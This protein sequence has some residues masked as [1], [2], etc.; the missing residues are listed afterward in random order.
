VTTVSESLRAPAEIPQKWY[1]RLIARAVA[2][3][4][5]PARLCFHRNPSLPFN[6]RQHCYACGASRAYVLNFEYE[7]GTAGVFIGPWKR[8]SLP[9]AQDARRVAARHLVDN[10]VAG[11][12]D[13]RRAILNPGSESPLFQRRS[14]A[15][16]SEAV[17][18]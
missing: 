4:F 10:A 11:L 2:S 14:V 13:G 9:A 6:D 3:R 17:A 5:W 16:Q 8:P 1:Q 18:R 12:L 15:A 7:D